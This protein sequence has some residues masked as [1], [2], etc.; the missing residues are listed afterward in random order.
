M[1]GRLVV[2]TCRICFKGSSSMSSHFTTTPASD[3]PGL[4]KPLP[5]QPRASRLKRS[6]SLQNVNAEFT[7]LN[8]RCSWS[9]ID[10]RARCLL[11]PHVGDPTAPTVKSLEQRPHSRPT[12]PLTGA[13]IAAARRPRE[14]HPRGIPVQAIAPRYAT[15][16]DEPTP[17]PAV[18]T[19]ATAHCHSPAIL[20]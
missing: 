7:G 8:C 14:H 12:Q 15:P 19:S 2:N 20:T 3:R 16:T 13:G 5:S 18:H 11:G 17:V 4:P 6:P 10:M 9:V 1:H